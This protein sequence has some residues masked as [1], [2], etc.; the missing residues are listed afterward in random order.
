VALWHKISPVKGLL[1]HPGSSNAGRLPHKNNASVTFDTSSYPAVPCGGAECDLTAW[2]EFHAG[3]AGG[4]RV[5]PSASQ[6]TR[7]WLPLRKPPTATYSHAGILF[8][9]GLRGE[10]STIT[11]GNLY[12]YLSQEHIATTVGI[13]LGL[14]ASFR[15]RTDTL[16]CSTLHAHTPQRSSSFGDLELSPMTQA[17]ALVGLGLVYESSGHWG[18]SEMLLHEISRCPEPGSSLV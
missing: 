7:A 13:L 18:T 16:A 5:T 17:A 2:P 4:L 3:V 8:A 14:G 10:L 11:P 12:R 1:C 6:L 9:L 15:A